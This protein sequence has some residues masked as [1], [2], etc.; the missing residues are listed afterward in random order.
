MDSSSSRVHRESNPQTVRLLRS[1]RNDIL[2]QHVTE[3]FLKEVR[4]SL[5]ERVFIPGI[6][7]DLVGRPTFRL[8]RKSDAAAT[9]INR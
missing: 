5:P 9:E 3:G 7:L 6:Q 1:A 4:G 8:F 2:W